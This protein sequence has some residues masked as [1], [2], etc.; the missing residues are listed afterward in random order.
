MCILKCVS[1]NVLT[2][3]KFKTRKPV[4]SSSVDTR[5]ATGA[6]T[7]IVNKM[8]TVKV[9]VQYMYI[10]GELGKII[11]IKNV[12]SVP[13]TFEE[14]YIKYD[15]FNLEI[16]TIISKNFNKITHCYELY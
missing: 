8:F 4:D 13:L 5:R 2:R 14:N 15:I 10:W 7:F 16:N 12:K 9:Q 6:E 1:I 11:Q 3:N